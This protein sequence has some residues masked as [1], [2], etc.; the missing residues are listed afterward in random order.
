MMQ[1]PYGVPTYIPANGW[2][3]YR[4]ERRALRKT[5][6][7]LAF[8]AFA[9]FPVSQLL[10]IGMTVLFT[11]VNG[12]RPLLFT[13]IPTLYYLVTGL[14]SFLTI[15]LP[16]SF[17]L[18]LGRRP[19]ADTIRTART[20]LFTGAALAFSGLFLCF[21]MNIPANF[22]SDLAERLG[23]NGEVNTE[24]MKV[25]SI[26]D[27]LTLI[28]AVILI[29]PVVEEFCYRGIV[30]S[31]AR[32]W[33]DMTAVFLSALLFALAH[34]SVPSLPVVF[35]GGFVMAYLYVRTN[36]LWI[37]IAVH[38]LN[39]LLATLPI[40][41]GYFFGEGVVEPANDAVALAVFAAGV[42]SMAFLLIRWGVRRKSPFAQP[43]QKGVRVP[44]R[45]GQLF[46]N[47]GMICYLVLFAI[48]SGLSL[49]GVL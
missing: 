22:L 25:A 11:A 10:A 6:S 26:P 40:M 33:G 3:P 12:G 1:I 21:V 27:L 37:N 41:L 9:A 28:L 29:A 7:R 46:A 42:C 18:F 4:E 2:D 13:E 34:F 36:N 32:R 24:T 43:L 20:P 17:F 49:F 31:A 15:L 45:F 30:V 48:V 5:A 38:F 39:N 44:A 14:F 8:C 23:L 16:F 19:L 47:P 35:V